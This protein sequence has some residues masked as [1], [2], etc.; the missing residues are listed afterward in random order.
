M[1]DIDIDFVDELHLARGDNELPSTKFIT[2][3]NERMEIFTMTT[4]HNLE[5]IEAL[6]SVM[7]ADVFER[8]DLAM[9]QVAPSPNET[10]DELASIQDVNKCLEFLAKNDPEYVTRPFPLHMADLITLIDDCVKLQATLDNTPYTTAAKKFFGKYPTLAVYSL[11]NYP[12]QDNS[13]LNLGT[14]K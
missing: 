10:P 14:E 11:A 7:P 2:D 3:S 5:Q 1:G 12:R 13:I 8:F 4:K 6:K 9:Q